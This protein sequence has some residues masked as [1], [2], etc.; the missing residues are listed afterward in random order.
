MHRRMRHLALAL[1]LGA[2]MSA[3]APDPAAQPP[4]PVQ[5][6]QTLPPTPDTTPVQLGPFAHLESPI[7]KAH[8]PPGSPGASVPASQVRT[9]YRIRTDKRVV[10]ITVDDGT[11]RSARHLQLL[12]STRTPIAAF[13][14]GQMVNASPWYWKS[15]SRLPGSSVFSHTWNH[16]DLTRLS[17]RQQQRQICQGA[18]A[19]WHVTGIWPYM[20]RPPYGTHNHDTTRAVAACG[21]STILLWDVVVYHQHI[22]TYGG[23]IVKGD[24]VLLHYT[25]QFRRDLAT[26]LAAARRHH[27]TPADIRPY[28][29]A[30]SAARAHRPGPPVS[31]A[32]SRTRT[33]VH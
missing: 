14:T 3:A 11:I 17:Y 33:S 5:S 29:P 23:P 7:R 26:I 25:P 31:T 9:V 10:F 1:A 13:P 24:I 20:F 22:E 12:A 4:A 27:L 21:M 28:L 32:P 15:T 2:A 8:H 6:E 30:R 16:P 19:T 18:H